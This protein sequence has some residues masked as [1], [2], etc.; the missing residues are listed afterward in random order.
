MFES[1]LSVYKRDERVSIVLLEMIFRRL[2]YDEDAAVAAATTTFRVAVLILIS[3]LPTDVTTVAN[4]CF[5]LLS[6]VFFYVF[7]RLC[8]VRTM[9]SIFFKSV[10]KVHNI[11][12]YQFTHST[13][14]WTFQL[15]VIWDWKHDVYVRS[16]NVGNHFDALRSSQS[17]LYSFIFLSIF[18]FLLLVK[19]RYNFRQ[20]CIV[21]P[22]DCQHRL[23][24]QM[25]FA[26]QIHCIYQIIQFD[27]QME[28]C[29]YSF[30]Y[31][32]SSTHTRSLNSK[33]IYVTTKNTHMQHTAVDFL[34]FFFYSYKM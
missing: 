18:F 2:V 27:I 24:K 23:E 1:H 8:F 25:I 6:F 29:K 4:F 12:I 21:C 16:W 33:C 14:V 7:V 11:R 9:P 3:M 34:H 26:L 20:L 22:F 17:K 19:N 32:S 28:I 30:A 10:C 31:M 13:C 15:K 5:V